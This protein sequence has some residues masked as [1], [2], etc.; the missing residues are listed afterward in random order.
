MSLYKI[1]K[2]GRVFLRSTL[3]LLLILTLTVL[4]Y[5]G[6][7]KIVLIDEAHGELFSPQLSR[8]LDYSHLARLFKKAG[9]TIKLQEQSVT[10]EALVGVRM[11]VV[12][13]A[14]KE[15]TPFEVRT[16]MEYI[17]GGGSLL[18]LLHVSAP[19]AR[20][21]EQ[22]GI[23]V[24]NVVIVERDTKLQIAHEPLNFYVNR[25]QPHPIFSKVRRVAVYG[26]WGL[27]AEGRFARTL[28]LTSEKAYADL[29][30]NRR[31]DPGD[32]TQ[33][34]GIV[35]SAELQKGKILVI[36]DDALFN[37][38]FITE[39][40]NERFATNIIRWLMNVRSN[41]SSVPRKR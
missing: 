5:G 41:D 10:P 15:F 4:L 7:P 22:L 35:A 19:L 28:A 3:C 11:F 1:Q 30:K 8:P 6:D 29:D 21:T 40:D 27:L 34:F 38:I 39:G 2:S 24:S 23:I 16:I 36:G 25:F 26:S 31:L 18:I 14:F 12:S 17:R 13:G 20:L 32:P 9:L 37:N 33:S